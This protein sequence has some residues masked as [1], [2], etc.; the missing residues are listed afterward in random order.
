MRLTPL[1]PWIRARIGGAPNAPLDRQ[2]L[3][4]FQLDRLRETIALARAGSPFYRDLLAGSDGCKI[5][6]L[7]GIAALPFTTP[8]DLGKDDLKFLCVSRDEVE[9]VVT[10]QSSGTTAPAKRLH[11]TADDLEMTTDFFHHG[12][13]TMVQSGDRVL[14][15][16][17]GELPGSVG[18]LLVKG[19]AR[20][21][22]EGVVHGLV[23]DRGQVLDEIAA[24]G[25]T[26]LVGIPVQLLALARH[27]AASALAGQVGSV[28]LSADH[29]PDAIVRE[30]SQ[31]WGAAVYN[32]YGMTEMGLGGA[33]ECA[34]RCGYHLREADLLVEIVDPASGNPL[35]DGEHG[36]VVFTTLT[37]RGMPLIRYRTGDLARV[38]PDPCPCGTVLRRMER[39][40]GRLSNRVRLAGGEILTM[41]ELDEAL[42]ALP[43]LLNFR[44]ELRQL[45]GLEVLHLIVETTEES[46]DDRRIMEALMT[47]PA[48]A[49]AFAGRRL[50]LGPIERQPLAVSGSIKRTI[51]DRRDHNP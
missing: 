40:A 39:V 43:F 46:D 32:H 42:F 34:H 1:E 29:V 7:R 14:I 11:F 15:L 12:M 3:E 41:A 18:D 6:S 47:V 27:P 17:P 24:K 49:S 30:I 25:I 26:C 36:E 50:L 44:P 31:T 20:R 38:I 33:V 28:L 13:S 22:V 16:M 8:A 2:E 19:L 10:L 35:P 9:R 51:V 45:A 21:G 5:Q 37:R 4:A 48:L 23:S